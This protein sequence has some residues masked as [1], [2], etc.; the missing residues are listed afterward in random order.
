MN[1]SRRLIV[2]GL[3]SGYFDY[4]LDLIRSIG[5]AAP[6]PERLAVLDLGLSAD[7]R[8]RLHDMDIATVQPGWDYPFMNDARAP[9]WFQAMTARPHLP[10]HFPGFETY[11]WIDADAWIQDWAPLQALIDASGGGALAIVEER[12]VGI[13]TE[14]EDADGSRRR[15]A[16]DPAQATA[17]NEA[18]WRAVFGDP[19]ADAIGRLPYFNCGVFALRGDSPHWSAWSRC[20]HDCLHRPFRKTAEQQ[21]L[22]ICIR[23]G[24]IAVAPQD[25]AANF[26]FTN[27]LPAY[28]E[29]RACFVVPEDGRKVGVMHL[30]DLKRLA[31]IVFPRWAGVGNGGAGIRLS[32]RFRV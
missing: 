25:I 30:C 17:Q 27:E 12:L 10:R 1:H 9:R 3:D 19:I 8:A 21:A 22:N 5:R 18:D 7:Q 23:R 15:F 32:P 2:T 20:L 13:D 11:V 16:L 14:I 28:D 24:E 29:S 31:G 4:G 6:S 26:L